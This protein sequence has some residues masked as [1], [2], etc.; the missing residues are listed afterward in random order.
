[1][2]LPPPD[3]TGPSFRRWHTPDAV[4]VA[5][6]RGEVNL[7]LKQDP[8]GPTRPLEDPHRLIAALSAAAGPEPSSERTP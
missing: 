3:F 6:S 4:V 8:D 5:T 7:Y 2:P 1:M